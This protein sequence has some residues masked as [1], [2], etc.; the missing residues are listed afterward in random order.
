MQLLPR[1]RF[2]PT[3]SSSLYPLHHRPT[4]FHTDYCWRD[5]TL[6]IEF[7]VSCLCSSQLVM[8]RENVY[9]VLDWQRVG[10]RLMVQHYL[11]ADI[12]LH[13]CMHGRV[14]VTVNWP[15]QFAQSCCNEPCIRLGS[16]SDKSICSHEG[17]TRWRF[18]L[19]PSYF[20]HL[21][22]LLG[23]DGSLHLWYSHICA[24]KRR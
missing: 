19:L 1:V 20:G 24:K 9:G 2:E 10:A 7:I 16:R 17:V 18:C 3:P 11:D 21:F 13:V 6:G 12:I 8:C 14:C 4:S 22:F 5:L 23:R 15:N